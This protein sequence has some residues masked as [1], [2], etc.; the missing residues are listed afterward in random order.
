VTMT[1]VHPTAIVESG[2]EIGPDCEIGPYA[3]ICRGVRMGARNRVHAF[4]VIGD[5]P[6]QT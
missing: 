6:Q 3:V 5:L 4:A 2:A 1:R